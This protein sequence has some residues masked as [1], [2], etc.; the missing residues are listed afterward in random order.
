MHFNY[1][2]CSE[3]LNG[4]FQ[5][6]SKNVL[7]FASWENEVFV[8]S[9]RRHFATKEIVF[10]RFERVERKKTVRAQCLLMSSCRR[11][12]SAT[13]TRL[14]SRGWTKNIEKGTPMIKSLRRTLF[15][16]RV[17][18][19]LKLTKRAKAERN[20]TK[21]RPRMRLTLNY[22]SLHFFLLMFGVKHPI[23]N[24]EAHGVW[25]SHQTMFTGFG[26]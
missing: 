21:R 24:C 19:K 23:R 7:R 2:W 12:D 13:G 14:C 15:I 10:P 17:K 3:R 16:S 25:Q 5:T 22:S 1:E 18:S 8:H 9:R 11:G 26:W 20:Q 4:S 6:G